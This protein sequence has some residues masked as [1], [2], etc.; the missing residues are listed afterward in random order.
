[1]KISREV[2]LLKRW[3]TYLSR[4]LRY[5]Y[6][7]LTGVRQL[8][9][10][11]DPSTVDIVH[12]N[13]SREDLGARIAKKYHK[14]LIWHF[15]EFGDR[16]FACYSYRYDYIGYMNKRAVKIL[17]V[18]DAVRSSWIDR[19]IIQEKIKTVYNGV[20]D[21]VPVKNAAFQNKGTQTRFLM[22]GSIS[23]TKG[24]WQVIEA[25]GHMSGEQRSDVM[26]DFVGG[27]AEQYEEKLRERMRSF[28]MDGTVRFLGYQKDY[29]KLASQY[30][31]GLMCSRSEGFGRVTAEYMMAGIPVIA[32]DSG[33]NPELVRD[34]EN[35]LL[36]RWEDVDD[37]K[38]KM[39]WMC[40][41][42]DEREKM[43]VAARRYA[44]ERFS[45][46]RNAQAVFQEYETLM[47]DQETGK[48]Q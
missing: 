12:S 45:A 27:V 9:R 19:G 20:D 29:Y 15:R 36:Y 40:Q 4:G 33:A 26:V 5:A 6:G 24:Q 34:G 13:S 47:R 8:E 16:D 2:A 46:K 3:R 11:M 37:L 21:T 32:S 18:S 7:H 31:C 17:A 41:H 43:G 39:L 22:M 10:K 44:A 1:M 30:D 48:K 25:L 23:D 38:D 14:P 42:P 35:G 28:G